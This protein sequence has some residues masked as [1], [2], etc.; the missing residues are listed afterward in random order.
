MKM[1]KPAS[2]PSIAALSVISLLWIG[3]GTA[4]PSYESLE[5]QFYK[6][7]ATLE[8]LVAMMNEDSQIIR[9]DSN[10]IGRRDNGAWPRPESE[11]GISAQRWDDYRKIFGQT[12]FKE[13]TSRAVGSD[14]VLVIV[15]TE[16]LVTSGSAI[17]Y[18]H[19]GP[20]TNQQTYVEPPCKE[21]KASG[22]G[23]Y[24]ASTSYGYRYKKL[25]EDW[26]IY[27]QSD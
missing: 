27:Q 21:R 23:Q 18:L 13:G 8:R 3:C 25:T 10:F 20:R 16:G 15:Y 7:R 24:P 1:L 11:W 6:Q 9:V 19:C 5:K 17:S 26:Y 14:D 2:F 12:G 22:S 4:A